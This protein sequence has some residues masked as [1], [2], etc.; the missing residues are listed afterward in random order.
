MEL[1]EG[2]VA[3]LRTI[4]LLKDSVAGI[5]ELEEAFNTTQ[6]KLRT[7]AAFAILLEESAGRNELMNA[8]EQRVTV[9]FAIVL[10]IENTLNPRG[11]V[12][13]GYKSNLQTVRELVFD[14]IMDYQSD[15]KY[16]PAEY[17]RG[18][19]VKIQDGTLWWQEEFTTA[20]YRR[21]ITT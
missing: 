10:A 19:L 18:R 1:L 14:K 3:Q 11:V 13:G 16:D 7:P 12:G 17:S 9:G 6:A 20:Y 15:A 4:T 21:K 5:E 2:L 8:I